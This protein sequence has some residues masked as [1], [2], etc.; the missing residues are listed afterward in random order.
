MLPNTTAKQLL[1][2]ISILML[3]LQLS[4][5]VVIG[6]PNLGFSQ[7]CANASFNDYSASFIFS[8]ENALAPS[9]QFTVEMSDA[10]GDF[11]QATVVFTSNPG[12]ITI[13]PATVSFSIPE[14]AAGEN[15]RIRIKSSAPI[16][17]SAPSAPFA[18]YYKSQDAPFTI[19]NLVE[20]AAFC[21]GGSYLL[22]IDNPGTG[23]NDSPLNYPAL[24]FNWFRETGPTT[25]EFITQG[26]SLEVNSVG[27]YFVETNYGTCT[28]NSFS[29]RVTVTEVTNGQATA[30]IVS[31]LGN[32][33]CPEQGL[34][35]LSTLGGNSYQWFK[36][37]AIIPGAT[38]QM[39][40]TNESGTFSVQVDL[41][42]CSASGSI[43]LESL[44]FDSSINV[45][46]VNTIEE[47]ESLTVTITHLANQPI[48]EWYLNDNLIADATSNSYE[49]SEVGDY[50]VVITE[51]QGCEG[52][53]SYDFIV[54]E[55]L[56]PF[57]AVAQIPNI[58][59]PNGDN[60][61]DTWII[62][63]QFVSGTNTE[64]NIYNNR[65]TLV[66]KSN[67]YQNDWP[68]TDLG[69]NSINQVYYYI[70]TTTDNKTE[71]GSITIIR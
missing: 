49:V 41:G 70:I 44:L 65:G 30:A 8:P 71:K 13:S 1:L 59:S 32:P 9:N 3:T 51:T 6:T 22:T 55:A 66:F 23:S 57:P 45:D 29:N 46:D 54:E 52:S 12:A 14:T 68:Q 21:S 69:L 25:S 67:N 18:S 24:T 47:G 39:Y 5:Q 63:Q 42:A 50:T 64:I 60:I 28:S 53:L 35:T 11:S 62:P 43:N 33:Y 10:S 27:T 4:A 26:E 7:A 19:N 58:V 36:D 2:W 17:T 31:S 34:T 56:D 48:F 37:G 40:Q 15:Y 61:N 38:N 20:T 16:A